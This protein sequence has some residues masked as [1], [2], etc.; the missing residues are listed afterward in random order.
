VGI[1]KGFPKS[2]GRVG[3]PASWL[4]LLCHFHACFSRGKCW[5]NDMPPPSAM[6]IELG[7]E[8]VEVSRMSS[9]VGGTFHGG[10]QASDSLIHDGEKDPIRFLDTPA[11]VEDPMRFEEGDLPSGDEQ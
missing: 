11:L 1:P 8:K 7:V 4:S 9:C 2:V 6:P 10:F 5:L 3:R